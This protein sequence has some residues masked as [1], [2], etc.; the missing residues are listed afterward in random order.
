MK[1]I[2]IKKIMIIL[3]IILIS[4]NVYNLINQHESINFKSIKNSFLINLDHRKDRL[5]H[6]KQKYAEANINIPLYIHSAVN[7]KKLKLEDIN[8][9]RLA[10]KEITDAKTLGYRTKHYQLTMG[11]IGCYLS[12]VGL[13]NLIYNKGI[14]YALIFEDYANIPPD[15]IKNLNFPKNSKFFQFLG[16]KNNRLNVLNFRFNNKNYKNMKISSKNKTFS[17]SPLRSKTFGLS[18]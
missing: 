9:T 5:Q 7:G 14:D 4:I 3:L 6:F 13:W 8:I 15:F 18:I 12:H 10:K 16:K 1:S 17:F 11:G 2:N